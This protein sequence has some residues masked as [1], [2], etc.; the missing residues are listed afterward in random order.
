MNN[1]DIKK[2]EIIHQI[3]L[4]NADNKV[5][6]QIEL[7]TFK[8]CCFELRRDFLILISKLII[9]VIILT[10]CSFQL[11]TDKNSEIQTLYSGLIGIVLG[12]YLK[13]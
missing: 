12:S 1:D 4:E 6:N 3:D 2:L 13:N 9:S 7:D 11:I 10:L 5:S 8:S